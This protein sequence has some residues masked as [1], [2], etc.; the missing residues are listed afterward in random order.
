MPK[1]N[2]TKRVVYTAFF[3]AL[4]LALRYFSILVPFGGVLGMRISVSGFFSKLPAILFGPLYGGIA[5]GA[6]DFIGC[7]IKPDGE[8]IPLLTL[9]AALGGVIAG[10]AWKYA[11]SA[12]FERVKKYFVCAVA[13][14]GVWGLVNL[15]LITFFPELPYCAAILSMGA[16]RSIYATAGL[17]ALGLLGAVLFLADWFLKRKKPEIGGDYV[18]ML[19]VLLLA[20]ITVTTLNTFILRIF[21]PAL[22]NI[23]FWIFYIPR[24]IEEIIMTMVQSYAVLYLLKLFDR[25][26]DKPVVAN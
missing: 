3:M 26:F 16:K 17:I 25:V 9:T 2:S 18:K 1:I 7:I 6:I 5:N 21:V 12:H 14:F 4:A 10:F 11:A 15:I 22:A 23:A 24:L 8:Y 13:A 19:L 20:N